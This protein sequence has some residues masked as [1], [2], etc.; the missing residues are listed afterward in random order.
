MNKFRLG[1]SGS[2]I[3]IVHVPE[4]T[5]C[6]LRFL[7]ANV[8]GNAYA[9]SMTRTANSIKRSSRTYLM[10]SFVVMLYLI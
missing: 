5:I 2:G 3:S 9:V 7:P 10:V 4:R 6:P 1:F 8:F